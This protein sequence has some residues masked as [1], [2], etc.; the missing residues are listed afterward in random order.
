MSNIEELSNELSHYLSQI[1]DIVNDDTNLEVDELDQYEIDKL[2]D[3]IDN[4][5]HK[6]T[7]PF[8]KL[9]EDAIEPSY[10]YPSDS[11]FD[12]YSTVDMKITGFGRGLIPTGLK[13]DIPEGYEMQVR[14]KSGLA[15]NQGLMVLNSP[16]TVDQGFVGEI[17]VIIYN[18]NPQTVEIKKGQKIAQAVIS[19]VVSGD[20]INLLQSKK[21]NNKDRGENGFGSTGI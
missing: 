9:V 12:L 20:W 6:I 7:L 14:S 5:K 2:N 11:G 19:P 8:E 10:N 17:K 21:I 13:F 18:T 3:T 16:G 1:K 15:I 4:F